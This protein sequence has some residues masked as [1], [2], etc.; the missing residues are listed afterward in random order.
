VSAARRFQFEFEGQPVPAE[1]GD[2][3]GAALARAGR[4]ALA[5]GP[6][7]GARGVYC[8]IGV[9]FECV[10]EVEGVG[11]VRSC[12]QRAEPGMRVRPR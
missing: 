3:V 11:R 10:V 6:G 8:G 9:C 1:P 2:T 5:V 4:L 12:L 7:G